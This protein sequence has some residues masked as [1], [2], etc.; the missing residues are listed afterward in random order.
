MAHER[1]QDDILDELVD[2]WF[3]F[4]QL[5]YLA[6][7]YVGTA[8][9]EMAEATLSAVASLLREG[10]IVVGDL[11]D[12]FE[13]WET[14]GDEAVKRISERVHALLNERG[15]VDLG[16]TCWFDLPKEK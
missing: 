12:G 13:P 11:G 3:C 15:S 9:R 1:L 6:R 5:M 2:D 14:Q 10:K 8:E 7:A 4:S 16:E